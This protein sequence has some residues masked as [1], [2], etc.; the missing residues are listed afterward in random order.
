[1]SG[2]VLGTMTFGDTVSAEVASQMLDVAIEAGVTAIDTA[3]G[4]ARGE[5][6][7]ILG[8]VL[9]NRRDAVHLATKAGMPNSDALDHPLLSPPALRNCIEGSLQ[10][11]A[12]DR[13]ELLYLHQP[14][15][16]TPIEETVATL[17]ELI[18]E[19]KIISYGVSNFAAWQVEQIKHVAKELGVQA[20]AISQQLHN[21][22]ARR[23]EDEYTA[24]SADARLPTLVYNPLAGGILTGRHSYETMGDTGRFG[25]SILAEMYKSRYWSKEVFETVTLLKTLAHDAGLSLIELSLR[26]LTSR[27]SVSGVL[28]GGSSVQHL[29][30]NMEAVSAGC[31]P[32]DVVARCDTIS[33]RLAGSMPRYNR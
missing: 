31:L 2:M 5:S 32:A 20:P 23:I 3:N 17:G 29:I 16:A 6:E 24:F 33:A 12:T 19:G 8:Q 18:A 25:D 14:D 4:Y 27:S 30:G 7:K 22:V 11:L 13:V 10:R 26:W 15:A 28:L 21:L 9:G 1:M